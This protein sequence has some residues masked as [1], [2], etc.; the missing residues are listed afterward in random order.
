MVSLVIFILYIAVMLFVKKE[1]NDRLSRI[2]L[3]LFVTYW[4]GSLFMSSF[5]INGLRHV[6]FGTY[7]LLISSVFCFILGCKIV[8][9]P[10]KIEYNISR[11]NI[12]HS[13]ENIFNSKVI[14]LLAMG[15][16]IYLSFFF[17]I[18]LMVSAISGKAAMQGDM[19]DQVFGR[20][21][22]LTIYQLILMPFFHIALSLISLK[23]YD[24]KIKNIPM[25]TALVVYLVMFTIVSGSKTFLIVVLL[26]FFIAN[27]CI[28][29]KIPKKYI[30][31]GALGISAA[32]YG[33]SVIDSF[34][35][36]GT[37]EYNGNFRESIENSLNLVS[38]YTTLPISMFDYALDND[39][40]SMFGGWQFGRAS[41]AGIDLYISLFLN[42]VLGFNIISS[43]DHIINYLQ[44]TWIPIS[45]MYD[46]NY[47]YTGMLYQY[48]D[49][50]YIG[51]L[52]IPY[53]FGIIYRHIVILYYKYQNFVAFLL[54]GLAFFMM[55]H[56]VFTCYLIK[57]WVYF[58]VFG[59][60]YLVKRTKLI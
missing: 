39:Y 42:K 1:F 46:S 19:A 47:A 5:D 49:F 27:I 34:R 11:G 10:S 57:N 51:L 38:N 21:L 20:G 31:Y 35:D 55:M 26:Y 24:L 54:L 6:S 8:S 29:E 16:T 30:I 12:T 48:L 18:A 56:S 50:G 17:R 53:L 45:T 36:Y 32:L 23:L 3:S 43:N 58:Y 28:Y 4:F 44:N 2:T 25:V 41:F 37:I 13:V 15:F 22:H 7:L 40:L 52:T 14:V 60:L 59:L 9:F 33:I